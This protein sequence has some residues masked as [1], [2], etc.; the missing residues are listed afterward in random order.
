[1]PNVKELAVKACVKY[2]EIYSKEKQ[3]NRT[4]NIWKYCSD[5]SWRLKI[6]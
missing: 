5:R 3:K 6:H 2:Y 1:M 4:Y